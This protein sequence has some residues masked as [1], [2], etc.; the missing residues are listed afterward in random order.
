MMTLSSMIDWFVTRYYRAEEKIRE[1]MFRHNLTDRVP[2]SDL[3]LTGL[4]DKAD[5][6]NTLRETLK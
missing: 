2:P 5:R 4:L 3:D 6:Q 1:A